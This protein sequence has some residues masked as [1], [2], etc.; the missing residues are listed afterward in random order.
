MVEFSQTYPHFFKIFGLRHVW[1]PTVATSKSEMV[2]GPLMVG[3]L[4]GWYSLHQNKF[5]LL[6]NPIVARKILKLRRSLRRYSFFHLD[7]GG[8]TGNFTGG[9]TKPCYCVRFLE[10]GRRRGLRFWGFVRVW[11]KFDDVV[12]VVAF[13]V[14]GSPNLSNV[15][16]LYTSDAADE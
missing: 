16:L 9:A 6:G 2:L 15:C 14:F 1:Y 7:I 12:V 8:D 10:K 5:L 13:V 11:Y 3:N 4:T